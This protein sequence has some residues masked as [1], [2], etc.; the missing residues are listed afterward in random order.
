MVKSF[1]IEDMT[2]LAG[3]SQN[4]EM[5]AF[6][7]SVA[8]PQLGHNKKKKLPNEGPDLST[9][10][11]AE[12]AALLMEKNAAKGAS[13]NNQSSRYRTNRVLAHHALAQE[14]SVELQIRQQDQKPTKREDNNEAE[15]EDEFT[16]GQGAGARRQ[17]AAPKIISRSKEKPAQD[18]STQHRRKRRNSDDSSSSSSSDDSDQSNK[19]RRRPMGRGRR[20]SD[21]DTSSGSDEE[22]RRRARLRASRAR[23]EPVVI[24]T[25]SQAPI[26][27]EEIVA[28]E[29]TS[30]KLTDPQKP[31]KAS[32]IRGDVGQQRKIEKKQASYTEEESSSDDDSSSSGDSSSDKTSS[33]SDE[34]GAIAKPVFVPKHKRNLL[35]SEEKKWEEEELRIEREKQRAETR[36]MESRSMVARTVAAVQTA[37]VDDE[38]DEEGG[39]ATNAPPN[40]D[41][42]IDVEKERDAWEVR[43]LRRL[44]NAMDEM[45]RREKEK[46]EYELRKQMTDEEVLQYDI[47]AGRYHAPGS[48]REGGATGKFTQRFYHRGAYY[49]AEDEWDEDDVRHKAADYAKAATGEDKI[50][51]SALPEVMQAKGFGFARQNTRYKGLAKEDT[52]DKKQEL[53]PLVHKKK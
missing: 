47:K 10:S 6:R 33:S 39:G 7:P 11:A 22:D 18:A 48:N 19:R 23:Q 50:D 4:E 30:R 38:M 32:A 1:G 3:G 41:D 53:L 12:T 27:K 2:A 49:M 40:D 8:G 16:A 34:E 20:D 46:L 45:K 28:E 15:S 44:L 24:Q 36:K 26:E 21:D 35:Q 52:A 43:E 5:A 37:N 51:R 14:L 25:V 31:S 9:M 42:A 13:N 29:H 17:R